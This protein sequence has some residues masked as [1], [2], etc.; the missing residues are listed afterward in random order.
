MLLLDASWTTVASAADSLQSACVD[1]I[2]WTAH[3]VK[4]LGLND[5]LI[6]VGMGDGILAP[7]PLVAV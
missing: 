2:D 4:A 3:Q 7:P 5:A 6:E 1:P